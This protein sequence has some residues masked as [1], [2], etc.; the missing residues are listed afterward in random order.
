MSHPIILTLCSIIVLFQARFGIS[1]REK[2]KQH[3]GNF[4]Y[5]DFYYRIVNFLTSKADVKW[6][7]SLYSYLNM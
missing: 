1:S 3:D 4:D 2:W 5:A 7:K 6:C